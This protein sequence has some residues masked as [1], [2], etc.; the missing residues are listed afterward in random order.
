VLQTGPAAVAAGHAVIEIDAVIADS[1]LTER[2]A[3]RREILLV[4]RAAG[5]AD[6]NTARPR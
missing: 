4:G 6:Q 2:V 5:V 3:L 1:E